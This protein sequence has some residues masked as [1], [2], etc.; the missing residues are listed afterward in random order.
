NIVI[1]NENGLVGKNKQNRKAID[2]ITTRAHL[3]RG[4]VSVNMQYYKLKRR[5]KTLE[6]DLQEQIKKAHQTT[7]STAIENEEHIS[8]ILTELIECNLEIGLDHE[9]KYYIDILKKMNR[10]PSASKLKEYE[11]RKDLIVNLR[12]IIESEVSL[13]LELEDDVKYFV[14][15]KPQSLTDYNGEIEKWKDIYRKS[16]SRSILFILNRQVNENQWESYFSIPDKRKEILCL[17][18]NENSKLHQFLQHVN[19]T[20]VIN[21]FNSELLDLLKDENVF[22]N[23]DSTNEQFDL[24][25][26]RTKII[27]FSQLLDTAYQFVGHCPLAQRYHRAVLYFSNEKDKFLEKLFTF[28]K[29]Q[30]NFVASSQT[31]SNKNEEDLFLLRLFP[32]HSGTS[33]KKLNDRISENEFFVEILPYIDEMK[34]VQLSLNC[35]YDIDWLFCENEKEQK[36]ILKTWH[37][38]YNKF[39][40]ENP[41][42]KKYLLLLVECDFYF[43]LDFDK[44]HLPEINQNAIVLSKIAE[45][46]NYNAYFL[47]DSLWVKYR[48]TKNLKSV[49]VKDIH[50]ENLL[51]VSSIVSV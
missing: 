24:K 9:A 26:K 42:Q 49:I 5:R 15:Q 23:S 51:T 39:K 2:T 20:S 18:V 30:N 4:R 17:K 28:F 44:N 3:L 27:Y 16:N 14:I 29:I 33:V 36:N 32:S 41:Y 45:S 12:K 13:L 19:D 35:V 31:Q 48:A 40:E 6:K 37:E 47:K 11:L 10:K 7:A 21:S 43:F 22:S 38:K 25:S 34:D 1:V 8:K 46:S 50:L